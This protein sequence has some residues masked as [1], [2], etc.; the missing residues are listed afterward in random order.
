MKNQN[1]RGSLSVKLV[2]LI[3]GP[4]FKAGDVITMDDVRALSSG[5]FTRDEIYAA[6]SY[7][8]RNGYIR[9][10]PKIGPGGRKSRMFVHGK[11]AVTSEGKS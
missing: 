9:N 10:I 11:W 5:E 6:V 4:S 8:R 1:Q 3:K 2:E 7:V